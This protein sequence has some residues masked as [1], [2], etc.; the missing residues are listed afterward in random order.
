M[1]GPARGKVLP[2]QLKG[3]ISRVSRQVNG[4][5][6]Q[7]RKMGSIGPKGF[8]RVMKG[9]KM[10]GRLGGQRK[11]IANLKVAF[12]DPE[13]DLIGILGGIPGPRKGIITIKA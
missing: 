2:G 6:G 4:H 8:K 11:T 1:S 9:K 5:S 10:P 13:Q 7:L 3:I 12:I